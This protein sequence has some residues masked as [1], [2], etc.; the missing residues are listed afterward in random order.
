M[1]PVYVRVAYPCTR[2]VQVPAGQQL[3]LHTIANVNVQFANFNEF[4]PLN[5]SLHA[6]LTAGTIKITAQPASRFQYRIVE[7]QR[8]EQQISTTEKVINTILLIRAY[9]K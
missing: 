7:Q 6:N 1:E 9:R 5:E 2:T 8:R 4:G 3:K